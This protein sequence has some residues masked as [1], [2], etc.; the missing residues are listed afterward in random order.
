MNDF[1]W[2][3]A[4]PQQLHMVSVGRTAS[5]RIRLI[6]P[7]DC[8]RTNSGTTG[9]CSSTRRRSSIGCQQMVPSAGKERLSRHCFG[10]PFAP[11]PFLALG[12]PRKNPARTGCHHW[13]QYSG[14]QRTD[15]VAHASWRSTWAVCAQSWLQQPLQQYLGHSDHQAHHPSTLMTWI[16]PLLVAEEYS[17][18]SYI[19]ACPSEVIEHFLQLCRPCLPCPN[20]LDWPLSYQVAAKA[21]S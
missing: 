11:W 18:A 17:P 4:C 2:V 15:W 6:W 19:L 21:A 13:E 10:G 20:R 1:E 14:W 9:T 12:W 16:L 5:L 3:L 7:R 8:S